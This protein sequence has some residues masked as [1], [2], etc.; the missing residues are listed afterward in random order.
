M[1]LVKKDNQVLS[2]L[3]GAVDS[4]L[5]SGF[6]EVVLDKKTKTYAIARRATGGRTVSLA[7][8]NAVLEKLEQATKGGPS[9][10]MATYNAVLTENK[11]LKAELD[12][13]K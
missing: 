5:K 7:Q 6:D 12:K 1:A 4:F 2:V 10:P 11:K 8:Y 3:D 13:K 9:V